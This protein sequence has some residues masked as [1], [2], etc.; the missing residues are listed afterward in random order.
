MIVLITSSSRTVVTTS[1]TATLE[2]SVKNTL[3]F[4]SSHAVGTSYAVTGGSV[5]RYVF[6]LA[7]WDASGWIVP[8]GAHGDAASAHFTD[9]RDAW[10]HGELIPMRYDWDVIESAATA[11]T[12]L[13]P[14]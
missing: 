14:R 6:D 12:Q 3:V 5:A 8:L 4:A 7:N 13:Q 11:S 9:Q 10:A 2:R 1:V